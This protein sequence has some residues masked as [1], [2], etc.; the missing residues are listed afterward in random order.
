MRATCRAC[1]KPLELKQSP[2]DMRDSVAV[3]GV[4]AKHHKFEWLSN[5]VDALVNG[6]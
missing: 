2:D 3:F 6:R 1:S 5:E 4:V